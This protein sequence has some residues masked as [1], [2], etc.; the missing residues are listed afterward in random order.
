[1]VKI[2][3]I[4]VI[5]FLFVAD[6]DAQFRTVMSSDTLLLIYRPLSDADSSFYEDVCVGKVSISYKGFSERNYCYIS[7]YRKLASARIPV[8]ENI[9]IDSSVKVLIVAAADTVTFSGINA[10][11][12][13]C[14]YL[15]KKKEEDLAAQRIMLPYESAGIAVRVERDFLFL[16]TIRQSKLAILSHF[17]HSIPEHFYKAVIAQIEWQYNYKCTELC[18]TLLTPH[19]IFSNLFNSKDAV[20]EARREVYNIYSRQMNFFKKNTMAF[21]PFYNNDVISAYYLQAKIQLLQKNNK[22][23]YGYI[24]LNYSGELRD[25]LLLMYLGEQRY[26]DCCIDSLLDDAISVLK[27]TSC[28]NKALR[29]REHIKKGTFFFTGLLLCSD[30]KWLRPENLYRKVV[31]VDFWFTGCSGC[32]T[33]Y[34]NVLSVAEKALE[35]D[36][37]VVF[38][39]VCLD[40]DSIAWQHSSGSDNYTSCRRNVLNVFTSGLGEKHELVKYYGLR[41]YPMVLLVDRKGR[42]AAK[43]QQN[44]RNAEK[45]IAAV[46]EL[47]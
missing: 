44:I 43:C 3:I 30:G 4:G 26:K 33:N 46:K 21:P 38:L 35:K 40:E 47:Q 24:K 27:N 9:I 7:L 16:D 6:S 22:G 28:L 32:I 10:D 17:Y 42:L 19:S 1:M 18:Y 5:L 23:L 8:F 45:L 14:Q 36:T 11:V 15:L 13:R 12:L 31:V 2:C 25:Y 39:S 29:M 20:A 37:S 41:S 34:K